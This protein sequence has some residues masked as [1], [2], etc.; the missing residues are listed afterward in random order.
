MKISCV[1][2]ML[3]H[4]A[5]GKTL[6]TYGINTIANKLFDTGDCPF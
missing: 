5:V 6:P 2:L 1:W 4:T 3:S